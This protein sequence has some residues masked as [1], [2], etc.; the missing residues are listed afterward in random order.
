VCSG[1]G[2]FV[3]G[4]SRQP[5]FLAHTRYCAL[6]I[7]SAFLSRFGF[8]NVSHCVYPFS[9]VLLCVGPKGIYFQ[10]SKGIDSPH[11]PVAP[12]W[13]Q[14]SLIPG[15]ANTWYANGGGWY[16][17][18]SALVRHHTQANASE[19][20]P[21]ERRG[22]LIQKNYSELRKQSTSYAVTVLYLQ[23]HQSFSSSLSLSSPLSPDS[24]S[25]WVP[26]IASSRAFFSFCA[27]SQV[28]FAAWSQRE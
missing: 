7:P 24:S 14:L 4:A 8:V 15:D 1:I 26:S 21:A 5:Q 19:L 22:V 23:A 27:F 11:L 17:N 2:S 12:C 10:C 3:S 6:P 28:S 20:W 13:R 16:I 9:V 25:E 18:D